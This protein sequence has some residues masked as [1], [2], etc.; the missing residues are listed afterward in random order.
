MESDKNNTKA[1]ED[2]ADEHAICEACHKP[3]SPG[4]GCDMEWLEFGEKCY[5]RRIKYGDGFERVLGALE[6]DRRCHDCNVA[7]GQY[8]HIGCDMEQCP[9]CH[10]QLISCYCGEDEDK[11]D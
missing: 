4:N 7:V 11:K 3:M 10:M 6:K 9:I 5:R 2:N 8:H 1:N